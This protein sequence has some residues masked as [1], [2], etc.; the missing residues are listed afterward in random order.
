[1]IPLSGG[2]AIYMN[3]KYKLTV[4]IDDHIK[5]G[6]SNIHE[7]HPTLLQSE[8]IRV[9]IRDGLKKYHKKHGKNI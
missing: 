7:T 8:I 6:L 9:W 1:L 5:S 2:F 3:Y 4:L